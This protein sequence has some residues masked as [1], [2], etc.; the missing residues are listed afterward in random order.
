M[1]SGYF[2]F[3]ASK[4]AAPACREKRSVRRGEHEQAGG[5][6]D[7]L[8]RELGLV[9]FRVLRVLLVLLVR[10]VLSEIEESHCDLRE[11]NT[12]QA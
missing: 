5:T 1:K 12:C 4:A 2:T 11:L 7:E 6:H 8:V 10:V 9:L 3:S